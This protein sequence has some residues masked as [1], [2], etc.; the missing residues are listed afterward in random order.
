MTLKTVVTISTFFPTQ[1]FCVVNK[2]IFNGILKVCY[3]LCCSKQNSELN[4]S[5]ICMYY[6]G[7]SHGFV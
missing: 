3:Q 1:R 5:V 2:N 4:D 6:F 7:S